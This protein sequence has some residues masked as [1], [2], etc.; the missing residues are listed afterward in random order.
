MDH[1]HSINHL[2]LHPPFRKISFRFESPMI[3]IKWKNI[4]SAMC[5]HMDLRYWSISNKSILTWHGKINLAKMKIWHSGM[6]LY[7]S[8]WCWFILGS[9]GVKIGGKG[10]RSQDAHHDQVGWIHE[11][12]EPITN[13]RLQDLMMYPVRGRI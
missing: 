10:V 12:L 11:L 7:P 13:Y 1:D 2:T 3:V 6:E 9:F 4:S 8:S 5:H